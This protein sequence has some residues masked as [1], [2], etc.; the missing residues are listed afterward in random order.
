M[1]HVAIGVQSNMQL[2]LLLFQLFCITFT[3]LSNYLVIMYISTAFSGN[4]DETKVVALFTHS[5]SLQQFQVSL[6]LFQ[7]DQTL[8]GE[9]YENQKGR[10]WRTSLMSPFATNIAAVL[11]R[12]V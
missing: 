12:Y 6:G 3:H 11:Y 2:S 9:N 4:A 5:S 8:T 7:D 10:K 1:T